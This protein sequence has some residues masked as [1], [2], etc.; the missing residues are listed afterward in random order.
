M[1]ICWWANCKCKK[2]IKN[3]LCLA[4][5]RKL[6]KDF[7]PN[8]TTFNQIRYWKSDKCKKWNHLAG[9]VP[10]GHQATWLKSSQIA[11]RAFACNWLNKINKNQVNISKNQ[12]TSSRIFGVT[13]HESLILDID[14]VYAHKN[15]VVCTVFSLFSFCF[16]AEALV[17]MMW[18]FLD[19]NNPCEL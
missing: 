6:V 8:E 7:P 5:Y 13:V 1:D 4:W 18:W 15:R 10:Q 17:W 19:W 14:I 9:S 16:V 12:I 3:R 2:A 11:S